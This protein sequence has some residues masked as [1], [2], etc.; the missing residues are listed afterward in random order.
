MTIET[1][2]K[3][4]A[5]E[6]EEDLPSADPSAE[7]LDDV[8]MALPEKQEVDILATERHQVV[9]AYQRLRTR[10]ET[11]RLSIAANKGVG[12][13]SAVKNL[14]D[15]LDDM[16]RQIAHCKRGVQHIDKMCPGARERMFELAEK[17]LK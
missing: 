3:E 4:A 2:L 14:Q 11:V 5:R 17:P 6:I 12:N 13:E 8:D 1:G 7:G 16:Q 10:A 15:Q 9:V